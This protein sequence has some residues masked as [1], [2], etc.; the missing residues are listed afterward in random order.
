MGCPMGDK[1]PATDEIERKRKYHREY[2]RARRAANPGID[3]AACKKWRAKN[4]EYDSQRCKTW[5][6]ENAESVRE[7]QE[8]WK[9][10]NPEYHAEWRAKN[11][12]KTR[13]YSASY[14]VA[15]DRAKPSWAVDRLISAVYR[16]AV[17]LTRLTGIPHEVD[18]VIPLKGRNVCGLHIH[19]N[20]RAISISENRSKGN[21]F[22]G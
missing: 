10:E 13:E 18:H 1:T 11:P 16:R 6:A 4:K 15:R 22:D 8:K 17:A 20:L 21:R 19:Q 14:R 12:L 3:K 5:K 2:N 9:A 7:Y